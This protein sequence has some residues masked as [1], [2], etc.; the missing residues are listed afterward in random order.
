MEQPTITDFV[1]HPN[2]LTIFSP[3]IN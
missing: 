1:Y 2:R 3:F